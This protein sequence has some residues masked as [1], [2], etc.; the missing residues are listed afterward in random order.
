[1]SSKSIMSLFNE[2]MQNQKIDKTIIDFNIKVIELLSINVL[3]PQNKDLDNIDI[4]A[5]EEFTDLVDIIDSE[6]QGREGIVLILNAML[7]LTEFLKTEKYIKGGKIA[8]YRRIFTNTDYYIDKYE[9][10]KGKKDNVKE[11]IRRVT[12]NRLSYNLIR[13]LENVNVNSY[14]TIKDVEEILGEESINENSSIIIEIL[15]C[16]N[17]IEQKGKKTVVSKRGRALLRLEPE[18]RYSAIFYSFLYEINWLETSNANISSTNE[19]IAILSS[20]FIRSNYICVNGHKPLN[21]IHPLNYSKD[22]IRLESFL[23]DNGNRVIFEVLFLNMGIIKKE[24]KK[25]SDMYYVTEFGRNILK[26]IYGENEGY[27]KSNID[28]IR[29]LIKEKNYKSVEIEIIKF[30]RI[31]GESTIMWDYLG[32]MLIIRKEYKEAYKIL[33]HA[34]D[35]SI[36]TGRIAKQTLSHLII[37][38]RRL[39]FNN[40]EEMYGKKYR[41]IQIQN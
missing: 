1:M 13:L 19:A 7:I 29:L 12:K 5:F 27:L 32:Q 15:K 25:E 22:S 30:I 33:S 24:T 26:L 8:Y 34:Y 3:I 17:L 10:I 38:C 28:R 9:S 2:Y 21:N 39:E 11:F 40:E 31:F 36:K 4:Y 35:T 20:V 6:L 41:M 14:K 37:C 18:E 23:K 16:I